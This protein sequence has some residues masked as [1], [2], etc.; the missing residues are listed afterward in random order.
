M[1]SQTDMLLIIFS[2]SSGFPAAQLQAFS[3]VVEN[4][5]AET[6]ASSQFS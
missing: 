3:S 1:T 4:S 5:G 6:N 2:S